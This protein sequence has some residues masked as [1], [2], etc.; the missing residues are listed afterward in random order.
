MQRAVKRQTPRTHESK[1]TWRAL[2]TRAGKHRAHL[3]IDDGPYW[4]SDSSADEEVGGPS[5]APEPDAGITYSFDAPRGASQG[6]DVLSQAVAQ[7]VDRFEKRE[8]EK[9]VNAEYDVVSR[10]GDG[11]DH[12]GE[13]YA[14]DDDFELI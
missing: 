5:P 11:D 4:T 3:R 6:G 8:T 10:D 9:L 7:A 2:A 13:G 1:A 12:D 14:A